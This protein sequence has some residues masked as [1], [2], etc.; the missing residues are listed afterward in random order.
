M[1]KVMNRL[2]IADIKSP[3]LHGI[4]TGHYFAV[5]NNYL[6]MFGKEIKT[7]I[8][9]SPVYKEK[10]GDSLLPL[11]YNTKLQEESIWKSK[12]KYLLNARHLFKE[13][14]GGIIV[15]QQGGVATSFIAIALFY[16]RQ[17]KLFLIQYSK[18]GL[19]SPFKRLLYK[20]A[21][22]KIDGIV[23]PNEMVGCAFGKRYCVVPDYIFVGGG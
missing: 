5:A 18:E 10:F 11:P 19:D 14:K 6:E 16:H 1:N 17:S 23:C 7:L 9:G 22:G 12:Q 21:K 20:L 13:G 2:I 15:L 3:S 4:S 8:A